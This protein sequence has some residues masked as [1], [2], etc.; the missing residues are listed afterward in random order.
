MTREMKLGLAAVCAAI[1]VTAALAGPR[2]DAAVKFAEGKAL[3]A[4]GDFAAAMKA[5]TA[6]AK[7]DP[8]NPDYR[9]Q[10]MLVRRVIKL[11]EKL[12]TQK[13]PEKWLG[14]ARSLYAFY[15]ENEIHTEALAIALKVHAEEAS[16]DSAAML[17]R[18]RLALNRNAE[19][20]QTLGS[21]PQEQVTAEV[22]VLMGVALARQGTKGQADLILEDLEQPPEVGSQVLFDLACLHSLLGRSDDAVAVLIRCFENT[23]AHELEQVQAR[24]KQSEDFAALRGTPAFATALTTNSKIKAGCGGCSKPCSRKSKAG[25]CSGRDG[26]TATGGREHPEKEHGQPCEGHKHEKKDKP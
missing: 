5:Y 7:A 9:V 8:D 25:K 21:V 3:L 26:Q 15:R 22:R 24:A 11:R 23:P 20:V 10:A 6:A 19:A 4:E 14:D 1:F 2:R 12:D 18:A 16:A 17:A 13:D